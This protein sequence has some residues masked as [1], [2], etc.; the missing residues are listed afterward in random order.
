VKICK[1]CKMEIEKEAIYCPYCTQRVK[2]DFLG[3][4]GEWIIALVIA[5]FLALIIGGIIF[6]FLP[7]EIKKLI[8]VMFFS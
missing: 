6:I 3:S 8:I 4:L 5:I 1:W 2:T 7:I